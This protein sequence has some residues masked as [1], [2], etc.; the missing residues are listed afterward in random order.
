M[1]KR[2]LKPPFIQTSGTYL[3]LDYTVNTAKVRKGWGGI[4]G[5]PSRSNEW[6]RWFLSV[7][8]LAT[9]NVTS[10]QR[11]DHKYSTRVPLCGIKTQHGFGNTTLYLGQAAGIVALVYQIQ[12]TTLKKK[13]TPKKTLMQSK[14]NLCK[15][16]KYKKRHLASKIHKCSFKSPVFFWQIMINRNIGSESESHTNLNTRDYN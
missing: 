16:H 3:R 15:R 6:M 12:T 7:T 8:A 13:K 11:R 14:N 2:S 1:W 4:R 9:G 10:Q 5:F